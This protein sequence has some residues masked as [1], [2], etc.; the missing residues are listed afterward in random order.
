MT[1]EQYYYPDLSH[2][3]VLKSIKDFEG[4]SFFEQKLERLEQYTKIS[5]N[6]VTSLTEFGPLVKK[7]WETRSNILKILVPFESNLIL[8]TGEDALVR[9]WDPISP[10]ASFLI[11]QGVLNKPEYHYSFI[12]DLLV[13][14]EQ[15]LPPFNIKKKRRDFDEFSFSRK[16]SHSH[17]INDMAYINQPKP[18]LFTGSNDGTIRIWR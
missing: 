11:G 18:L 2:P 9:I 5:S 8:S 6:F 14:Q 7:A 4:S 13:I 3:V 10:K 15:T 16:I 1:P 17:A 12:P